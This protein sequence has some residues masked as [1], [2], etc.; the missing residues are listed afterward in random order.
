MIRL[1]MDVL[2]AF[3][4]VFLFLLVVGYGHTAAGDGTADAEV[5]SFD[6][7]L[8]GF[9][10][11]RGTLTHDTDGSEDSCC[12]ALRGDF[13]GVA[14]IVCSTSFRGRGF[15][16]ASFRIRIP[17]NAPFDLRPSLFMKDKDGLWFQASGDQHL[18]RREWQTF[19]LDIAP[20]S[21]QV[22]PYGHEAVWNRYYAEHV[23]AVGL[24][25]FS[26][27]RWSGIIR[28][29]DVVF[30]AG[31]SGSGQPI[32][33][34]HLRCSSAR[35]KAYE[36]FEPAF[37]LSPEPA[38]PFDPDE[39]QV[40]AVFA[41]PS[42]KIMRM[43]CFYDQPCRRE[44][45]ADQVEVVTPSGRAC[46]KARFTPQEA[47]RHTWKLIV[48][49]NSERVET[50]THAFEV[51]PGEARGFVRVSK[52]DPRYFET[53]DGAF[54]YPIG[55]NIHAPFDKRCA[56]MLRLPVL[57]NRG[58]FAYDYYFE[59][60]A[61]S[62][63]NA[64]II[65]MSNWWVSIEWAEKWEGFHGLGDYNLLNAWRLD[66]I[67]D[68]AARHG[69]YVNLVL[70]NHGKLSAFVD[71]E[72]GTNPYNA[73]LGGPCRKPE[74]FFNDRWAFQAYKKRLRYI[75]ARWGSHPNLLG[76]EIVSELN[77]VGSNHAFKGHPSHASWCRRV[78][79]YLDEIDPYRRPITIQY[80][81]NW[82]SVD[83]KVVS[84]SEVDYLVGD[85]YKSGGCIVPHMIKTAEMN[86][87]FGKPTFSAEFGG[88]WNGTTP[89][90]LHADLH[91]GLWS[92]AMTTAAG[93]PFFWWFDY[94]D[95]HNLYGEYQA[96]ANFMKGED[97][98][99]LTL[100]THQLPV[101][102][103]GRRTNQ[104]GSVALLGETR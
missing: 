54:F 46:W 4:W 6:A 84:L 91:A 75:V 70:D 2:P 57:P 76:F 72:W 66:H 53:A 79:Q 68:A 97:K 60:M 24:G 88:N 48:R 80:S 95:R 65:W 44:L 11:T 30:H 1:R 3:A 87:R 18:T 47:G 98:R 81:N 17:D 5:F 85:V 49:A 25:V 73:V 40:D 55:E 29:D 89:A 67:L 14:S 99:G 96:L 35:P 45:G 15:T 90:R 9:S 78:A 100:T 38:N 63:Q 19:T 22:A 71:S 27:E 62:G 41:A 94:V 82:Q 34:L 43:P 12:L 21:P 32:R 37:S 58:T 103:N 33:I 8:E 7:S 93:A 59:K 64:A 36:P 10:A 69:I 39:M 86:G 26:A 52:T 50:K 42:G 13:P 28:I 101:L 61:R 23:V 104:L 102:K 20:G 16:Q 51:E 56:I 77:L 31:A 83:E 92:N 74:D